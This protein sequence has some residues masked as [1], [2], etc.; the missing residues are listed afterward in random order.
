[1]GPIYYGPREYPGIVFGLTSHRIGH[2]FNVDDFAVPSIIDLRS[3]NN[4][5]RTYHSGPKWKDRLYIN[6]NTKRSLYLRP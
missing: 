3:R 4:L 2:T 5:V 1:M 6:M